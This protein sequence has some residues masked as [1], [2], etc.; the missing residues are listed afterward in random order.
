METRPPSWFGTGAA[1]SP[2]TQSRR[3]FWLGG[4]AHDDTNTGLTVVV[5]QPQDDPTSQRLGR[6]LAITTLPISHCSV[7]LVLSLVTKNEVL[8]ILT[9]ATAA[10][11]IR[12]SKATVAAVELRTWNTGRDAPLNP[13]LRIS[14]ADPSPC[15]P[16]LQPQNMGLGFSKQPPSNSYAFGSDGSLKPPR[17]PNPQAIPIQS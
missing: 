1:P 11:T 7:W 2:M 12:A 16:M 14:H 13:N 5:V 4:A 15:P 9:T 17:P 6:V 10:P 3:E 8:T